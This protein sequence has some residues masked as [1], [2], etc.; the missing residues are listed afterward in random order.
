LHELLLKGLVS[1][2]RLSSELQVSERQVIRAIDAFPP[3]VDATAL[4]LE[5][6][7]QFHARRSEIDK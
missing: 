3:S 7:A 2:R 4:A 1:R 5:W 6:T